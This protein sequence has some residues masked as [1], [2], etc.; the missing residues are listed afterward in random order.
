LRILTREKKLLLKAIKR[1]YDEFDLI[2][3]PLL[4][5]IILRRTNKVR[6]EII[7]IILDNNEYL[8]GKML[9]EMTTQQIQEWDNYQNH[10]KRTINKQFKEYND[11]I[12]VSLYYTSDTSYGIIISEI[13]D[14]FLKKDSKTT[15]GLAGQVLRTYRTEYTRTTSMLTDFDYQNIPGKEKQWVYTYESKTRRNH[16]HAHDGVVSENGYFIIE[17]HKT[18]APGMFGIPGE[19]INC[20]CRIR[21]VDEP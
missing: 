19:D 17:G 11:K 16:H 10:I 21:L 3:I 4:L 13:G 5:R 18:K 6:D 2:A 14:R 1:D 12:S 7:K 15:R 20:R 9:S 8:K